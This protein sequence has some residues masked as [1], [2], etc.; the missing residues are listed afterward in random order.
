V[1]EGPLLPELSVPLRVEVHVS[2]TW[3]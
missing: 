1:M 3:N 2:R